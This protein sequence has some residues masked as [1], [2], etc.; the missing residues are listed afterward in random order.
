MQYSLN[1]NPAYTHE[2]VF[3]DYK[4]IWIKQTDIGTFRVYQKNM[5]KAI[6]NPNAGRQLAFFVMLKE[7]V[8]GLIFLGSDVLNLDARDKFLGLSKDKI[9]RGQQ[10]KDYFNLGVCVGAQPLSWYWNI[11]KLCALLACT[12]GDYIHKRYPEVNFKGITTTSLWGE[13]I[14]YDRIFKFIG[15]TKGY[16]TEH[17][18]D[19]KYKEIVKWLKVNHIPKPKARTSIK[20]MLIQQ[21]IRYHGPDEDV[22]TTIHGHRRG[23]YYHPAIPPEQREEVIKYW[24]YRWGLPRYERLKDK[25]PPYRNGL[26]GGKIATSKLPIKED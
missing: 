3:I 10:L 15:Y 5:S 17:I 21:Y 24:Y 4:D 22:Y 7:R 23:V 13:S 1:N 16:G 9:I 26:E 8:I 20:M 14:Q 6:W 11:G 18:S 19:K 12:L 2:N 25:E